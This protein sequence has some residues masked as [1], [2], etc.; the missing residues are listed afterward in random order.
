[1]DDL[2]RRTN[3][4]SLPFLK[5]LLRMFVKNT[6]LKKYFGKQYVGKFGDHFMFA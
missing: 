6:S 3:P 5:C 2:Q 4:P 1:M